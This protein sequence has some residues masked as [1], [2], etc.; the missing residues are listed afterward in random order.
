MRKHRLNSFFRLKQFELERYFRWRFGF[1]ADDVDDVAELLVCDFDDRD[2]A[3]VGHHHADAINVDERGFSAGA[4]TDVDGKLQ[5]VE[6]VFLQIF[7][8]PR[9]NFA[10]GGRICRQIKHDEQ[11]HNVVAVYGVVGDGHGGNEG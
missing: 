11:P 1:F 9:R 5:H 7:P 2:Q 8:E 6:P 10:L 3:L 4:M